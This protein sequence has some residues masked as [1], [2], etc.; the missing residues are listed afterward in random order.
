MERR[1]S[2]RSGKEQISLL[3]LSTAGRSDAQLPSESGGPTTL[4]PLV[5]RKSAD[6]RRKKMYVH[7]PAMLG[8]GAARGQGTTGAERSQEREMAMFVS[9]LESAQPDAAEHARTA[10]PMGDGQTHIS[11]VF[12]PWK[13]SRE[14]KSAFFKHRRVAQIDLADFFAKPGEPPEGGSHTRSG[15]EKK[16]GL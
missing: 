14:K 9:L 7:T 5:K 10:V 11:S 8:G 13:A 4:P 16:G 3:S 2:R 15:N 6:L 1:E 12:R